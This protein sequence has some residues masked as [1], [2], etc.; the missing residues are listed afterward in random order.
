MGQAA[1]LFYALTTWY[2]ESL[3]NP[4]S[5]GLLT[6]IPVAGTICLFIGLVMGIWRRKPC[7]LWFSVS[8]VLSHAFVVLSG[9]F[10]GQLDDNVLWP[11]LGF[12]L[13]QLLTIVFSLR[14]SKSALIP[15]ILIALF[16][17]S[18]AL[19]AWLIAAMSFTGTWL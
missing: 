19:Y 2:F 9:F 5:L 10:H 6:M 17:I 11:I 3:L 1:W 8:V 16:C 7:L 14:A 12:V 15:A 13:L 4:F 18:Y